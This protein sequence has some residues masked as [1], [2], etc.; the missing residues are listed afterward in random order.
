MSP[1]INKEKETS[2]KLILLENGKRALLIN[3]GNGTNMYDEA[4][5]AGEETSGSSI[6]IF[7]PLAV[8][9]MHHQ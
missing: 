6:K 5:M 3:Y 7:K 8:K 4:M 2:N 9:G 1:S